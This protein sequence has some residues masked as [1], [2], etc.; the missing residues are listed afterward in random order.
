MKYLLY[1]MIIFLSSS[2]S[3]AGESRCFSMIDRASYERDFNVYL[4]T[5]ILECL[6]DENREIRNDLEKEIYKVVASAK[7]P[8]MEVP[9][10]TI[11]SSMFSW[12]SFS[13]KYGTKN[14]APIDGREIDSNSE[15]VK[16][17]GSNVLPDF[18]GLFLRGINSFDNEESRNDGLQDPEGIN[19]KAG[20]FQEDR[21]KSH[22]HSVSSRT[23]DT[24]RGG[25]KL[26][27]KNGGNP[28]EWLTGATIDGGTETRP[29]NAAVYYYVKIN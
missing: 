27:Y 15:Y 29:K 7:K 25:S 4:L 1:I 2:I 3:W 19:R 24:G 20:D 23:A 21:I 18:R 14:W 5:Q 17:L 13:K 28:G 10:G 11:I 16:I 6:A 8:G 26:P 9:V 22:L 12:P